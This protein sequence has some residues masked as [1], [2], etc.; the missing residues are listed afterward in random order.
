MRLLTIFVS[1]ASQCLKEVSVWERWAQKGHLLNLV[2]VWAC[3]PHTEETV[4]E[5]EAA[6]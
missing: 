2:R 6:R 3:H 5:E 1:K 4:P